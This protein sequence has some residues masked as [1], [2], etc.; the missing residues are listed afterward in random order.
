[1]FRCA[2]FA[3]AALFP[4]LP[5][6]AQAFTAGDLVISLEGN[7]SNTGNYTDNQAAPLTL[8]QLSVN[9]VGSAAAAGTWMLPQ[10]TTTV[11]GVTNYALSGEY[12]S[13][14][15][16]VLQDS[17]NGQYLT[18]MGYGVNAAAFNANPAAYS[19]PGSGNTAL[20]QS[21]NPAVPRVVG[22]IGAD[23]SMDTSTAL[24]N[25]FNQ[26]NPRSAYTQDGSSFYVS[27]QGASKTDTATQ[28]VFYAARGATTAT[29]IYGATDTRDVQ[30]VG[31]KLYASLDNNPPNGGHGPASIMQLSG[32]GGTLP[33]SAAGVSSSYLLSNAANN[34]AEI[35]LNA[36]AENGV[37]NA[38]LGSG[39]YLSPEGY[40]FANAT[41]LYVADSGS[42]KNGQANTAGLG[43]GGLQKWVFSGGTWNLA[44]TLSAGLGL[45][46][47]AGTDGV[48]GLEGLTGRV[49]DGQ[50]YLYATSYTIADLDTSYLYG[51][52]D[53]LAATSGAGESF[54]TL[55]TAGPDE[56]IKGVAFAP[57]IAQVPEPSSVALVGSGLLGVLLLRRRRA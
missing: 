22:L 24:S 34:Y 46:N 47:N 15:E 45:V 56:N 48:T 44:Y 2:L 41:T 9:G 1:M 38:R 5:A 25:V 23:G 18:V 7:G 27:G 49:V 37:N 4:A 3:T 28:G 12:G 43:D 35:T 51:I 40:F 13:S 42:P 26:N 6:M 32:P 29:Q 57:Q 31:G 14:S 52:A 16:G 36:A 30:V 19:A 11:G 53:T 21:T 55:L 50:V 10:T 54:T 20:G 17:G 8:E 33:T 39:V